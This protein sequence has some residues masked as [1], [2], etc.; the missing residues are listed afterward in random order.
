VSGTT[1]IDRRTVRRQETQAEIVAAAW[2]LV[3]EHGIAGLSLRD[4][5]ARIGMRAQSLYSYFGSKDDIYDA[6]FAEGYRQALALGN[7]LGGGPDDDPYEALRQG[8]HTIVAFC[9][10]DPAR[11]QLLFQRTIPGFAPSPESYALALE[12]LEGGRSIL[13]RCGITD[14]AGLDLYTALITGI[15]DQQISNDPGGSRWS[16]LVDAA[17]D[18]Y[19]DHRCPGWRQGGNGR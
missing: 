8:A 17:I 6:M 9:T 13:A 12:F 11:Y 15:T 5:G 4:L 16:G 3:R 10:A 14:Q 19:L 2:E 18:M 7:E 1:N